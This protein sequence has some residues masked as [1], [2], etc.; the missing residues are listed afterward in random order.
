[1]AKGVSHLHRLLAVPED[2]QAC[3]R[4]FVRPRLLT[5]YPGVRGPMRPSLRA[6]PRMLPG[7][8]GVEVA[9][10]SRQTRQPLRPASSVSTV[11]RPRDFGN[12]PALLMFACGPE[13]WG[14][15]APSHREDR[16]LAHE[17][18]IRIN[19]APVLTLWGAVVAE[20]LG[21]DPDAAL[22]LGRAVAGL[23]AY[24]KGVSLGLFEPSSKVV[25]EH[26]QKAKV[27]T[28]LHVDVL[29]RAVPV[30]STAEGLRAL[31]KDRPIAPASVERYLESKFGENLGS[32]RRAMAKLANSLPPAEIAARAYHLYEEFRPAI[33]AGVKGWGA[34]GE[35][36]LDLI[37]G[38]S[39]R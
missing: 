10:Q 8:I 2:L 1:M 5:T 29:H 28:T 31:S 20:R 3:Q 32:A 19:R 34:A 33:P 4:P 6:W 27:G 36:D 25:D 23:N 37:E 16:N 9:A 26:L 30:T 11:A 14:G 15:V 7:W 13:T 17:R 24:S 35:L 39:E 38:L 12:R 22:T 21:F 18:T